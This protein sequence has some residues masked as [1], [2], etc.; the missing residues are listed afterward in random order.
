MYET[1]QNVVYDVIKRGQNHNL[2][3]QFTQMT[4]WCQWSPVL[5][6]GH[7]RKRKENLTFVNKKTMAGMLN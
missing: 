1:A 7:Q 3:S 6:V 4:F 5:F 2:T